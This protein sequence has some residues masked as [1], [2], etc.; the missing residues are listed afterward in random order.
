[1]ATIEIT[2]NRTR[3]LVVWDP[4]YAGK[5]TLTL[6]AA[7]TDNVVPAGTLLARDP[8]TLN[9]VPYVKG[10]ANPGPGLVNSVLR[11][12][13]EADA[14]GDF[15]VQPIKGGQVR[16]GDLVILADG[17]ASNI[18]AVELDGLRSF[19]IVGRSTNQLAELDNQ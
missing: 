10:G 5:E 18:D 9:L 19:G 12:A 17:D 11:Q 16:T 1:M 2:N 4:V 7:P 14:A 15:P 13:V 6:A 8:A 3:T